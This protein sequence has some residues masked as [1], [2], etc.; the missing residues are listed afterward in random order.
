MK[1]RYIMFYAGMLCLLVSTALWAAAPAEMGVKPETVNIGTFYTGMDVLVTGS[2]PEDCEAVAVLS[3]ERS[4]LHLK[5][6]GKALGLL[7]MNMGS[8]I[9]HDVPSVFFVSSLNKMGDMAG[10]GIPDQ[11]DILDA[12]NIGFEGL[13]KSITVEA[14]KN[15]PKM[16]IDELFK[17]K[18]NDGLYQEQNGNVTYSDPAE[19][20][21]SYK[22]NIKLPSRLSPG[23]YMVNV[24]TVRNGRIEGN[25]GKEIKAQLTGV[26]AFLASLAFDHGLLYGILATL[27]AIAS[28]LVIGFVFQGSKGGAH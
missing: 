16:Y 7:W 21:K 8:L 20:Y 15:D 14:D 9:Y 17:L 3:G 6:K 28:G 25:T 26:P 19:G 10:Q 5:E 27:I 12:R 11:K 1:K 2:I 4:E 23:N 13:E 22:I 24:Y 18:K